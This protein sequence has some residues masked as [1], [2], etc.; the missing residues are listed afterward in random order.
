[1]KNFFRLKGALVMT[2]ARQLADITKYDE[3]KKKLQSF[4]EELENS[5]LKN[6][7]FIKNLIKDIEQA[8]ANVNP[9]VYQQAGKHEMYEN[10]RAQ[11][12]QKSN[13]KSKNS[14][15]NSVQAEMMHSVKA[16]KKKI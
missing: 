3:A 15:Q 11:M 10:A 14:Y 2:E 7:E 9:V 13:L 8:I 16:M 4:K 5:F 12:Y 1:M 6:E